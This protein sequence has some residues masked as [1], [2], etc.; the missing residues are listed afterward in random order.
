MVARRISALGRQR[1]VIPRTY[2]QDI[3]TYLVSADPVRVAASQTRCGW[4][5]G[6]GI[7]LP[8]TNKQACLHVNPCTHTYECTCKIAKKGKNLKHRR[9]FLDQ[10]LWTQ[11][12]LTALNWGTGKGLCTQV[13]VERKEE[14]RVAC[15]APV[16]RCPSADHCYL[17]T[18]IYL[19]NFLYLLLP[20]QNLPWRD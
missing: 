17:D 6:N 16:S 19:N 8:H 2:W 4:F 9:V 3:F 15:Q 5:L 10:A 7:W 18:M 11:T 14:G 1:L 12:G 20:M 13:Q